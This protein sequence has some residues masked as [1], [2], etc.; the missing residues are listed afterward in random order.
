MCLQKCRGINIRGTGATN[1][2]QMA[3]ETPRKHMTL[4]VHSGPS[5]PHNPHRP[6]S[7]SVCLAAPACPSSPPVLALP[8]SPF[9]STRQD[10]HVHILGLR[11]CIRLSL[12][13]C[14]SGV[15]LV[16]PSPHPT[17]ICPQ[18]AVVAFSLAQSLE[19][20]EVFAPFFPIPS[21]GP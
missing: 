6:A 10:S 2:P 19:C 17:K 12:L 16:P 1:R 18:A 7:P 21:P 5:A 8:S 13:S 15:L 3:Q 20:L 4:L 14:H 11:F 9:D